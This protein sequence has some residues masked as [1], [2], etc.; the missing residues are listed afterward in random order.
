M[1]EQRREKIGMFALV[2]QVVND[3]G[4]WSSSVSKWEQ[5]LLKISEMKRHWCG[6][7]RI[8]TMEAHENYGSVNGGERPG[9]DVVN[10]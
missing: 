9:V 2:L 8:P 3:R 1:P 5:I 10:V 6:P 4:P 7:S